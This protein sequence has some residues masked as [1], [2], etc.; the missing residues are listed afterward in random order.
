[1]LSFNMLIPSISLHLT[2]P[3]PIFFLSSFLYTHVH[4]G[5]C[6]FYFCFG[7]FLYQSVAA[8][9]YLLSFFYLFFLCIANNEKLGKKIQKDYN[10]DRKLNKPSLLFHDL[11]CCCIKK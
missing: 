9:D 3:K 2:L 11:F 5:N 4:R 10:V 1:M 7:F 8:R 6:T